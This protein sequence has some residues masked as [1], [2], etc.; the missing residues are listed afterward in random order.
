MSLAPVV[1]G[2]VI[3]QQSNNSQAQLS[4]MLL[5][6]TAYLQNKRGAALVI[7]FV[8]ELIKRLAS[9]F[10][11]SAEAGEHNCQR[12]TDVGKGACGAFL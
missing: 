10:E 1:Y 6:A 11:H 2:N 7:S 4:T 12:L 3:R 8:R 5:S 9:R